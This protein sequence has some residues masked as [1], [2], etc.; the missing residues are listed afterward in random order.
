MDV[1][2]DTLRGQHTLSSEG[3]LQKGIPLSA[4]VRTQVCV[5]VPLAPLVSSLPLE[6]V[7]LSVAPVS[8][9]TTQILPR[10]GLGRCVC[11]CV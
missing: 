9:Q 6:A 3:V 11:L 8:F 5:S 10:E 2:R 1:V 7:H 4:D